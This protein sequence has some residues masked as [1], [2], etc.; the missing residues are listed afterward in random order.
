[1]PKVRK[2]F[3]SQKEYVARYIDEFI[4][5]RKINFNKSKQDDKML[6]DWIDAQ[7]DKV[8]PYLKRLVREDM[9]R[10]KEKEKQEQ[11]NTNDEESP[12]E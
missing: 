5:Y 9:E 8:S 7:P 1:M 11:Q 2:P 4:E 12:A 3:S 10:Q 6:L